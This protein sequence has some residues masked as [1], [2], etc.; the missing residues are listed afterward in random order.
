MYEC[1]DTRFAS[2]P[3]WFPANAPLAIRKIRSP[4]TGVHSAFRI[5]RREVD[6]CFSR[7]TQ[8][9]HHDHPKPRRPLLPQRYVRLRLGKL[10][11][12]DRPLWRNSWSRKPTRQPEKAQRYVASLHLSNSLGGHPAEPADLLRQTHKN[13]RAF[14]PPLPI[15]AWWLRASVSTRAKQ[16]LPEGET[17]AQRRLISS[18][19]LRSHAHL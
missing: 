13:R 18:A 15:R 6:R 1:T 12:V 14:A 4:K 2:V 9:Q 3:V 7:R 16:D 10:R 11:F 17:P 8:R 19:N 5:D